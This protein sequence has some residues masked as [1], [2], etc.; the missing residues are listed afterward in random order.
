MNREIINT[1]VRIIF[2]IV[3]ISSFS[4]LKESG[5]I[6][7]TMVSLLYGA[8]TFVSPIVWKEKFEFNYWFMLISGVF[9][10][11]LLILVEQML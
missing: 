2:G 8:I 6:I 1:L 9:I 4:T 7:V 11:P 10:L 5:Y 3:Y